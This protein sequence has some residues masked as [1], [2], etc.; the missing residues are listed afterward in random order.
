MNNGLIHKIH[1]EYFHVTEAI[2]VEVKN[3]PDIPKLCI[4]NEGDRI[5]DIGARLTSVCRWTRCTVFLIFLL[6]SPFEIVHSKLRAKHVFRL[7]FNR[8]E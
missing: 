3:D 8:F 1:R 6:V 2:G 7:S 5:G 4:L